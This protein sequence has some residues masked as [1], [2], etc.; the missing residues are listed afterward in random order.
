M[1]CRTFWVKLM[2]AALSLTLALAAS[3]CTPVQ[4]EETAETTAVSV[5]TEITTESAEEEAPT[6]PTY[7][8]N[9]DENR[10]PS[11]T[12]FGAGDYGT[13]EELQDVAP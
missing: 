13:K 12:R 4:E 10:V 1:A 9:P 6:L 5:S 11:E 3:G 8:R 7:E 2:T